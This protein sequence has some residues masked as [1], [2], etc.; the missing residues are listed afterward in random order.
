MAQSASNNHISEEKK[1]E[2]IRL[3]RD[4]GKKAS[5]VAKEYGVTSKSIYNWLARGVSKDN[6][7]LETSRLERELEMAYGLPGKLTAEATRPKK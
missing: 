6:S 5:E 4:G 2:I 7:A 1:L 3:V